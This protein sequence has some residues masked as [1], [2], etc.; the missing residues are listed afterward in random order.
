MRPQRTAVGPGFKELDRGLAVGPG[1]VD[2]VG[3]GCGHGA[4]DGRAH[5][6][7]RVHHLWGSGA[8]GGREAGCGGVGQWVGVRRDAV[9]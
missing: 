6:Q 4:K 9:G 5:E 2:P 1:A 3:K 8:V 7:D